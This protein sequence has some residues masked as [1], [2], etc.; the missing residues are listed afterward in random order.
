MP[1][2]T[3]PHNLEAERAV[4]GAC[5]VAADGIAVAHQVVGAGDFWRDA[6]AR[7]WR[8]IG[9]VKDDGLAVDLI[10]VRDRLAAGG[11][12]DAV[13][14]PAYVARLADG[15]PRSTNVAHY[16]RLV[17]K[18]ALARR[19]LLLVE[20]GELEGLAHIAESACALASSEP[21]TG[22]YPAVDGDEWMPVGGWPARSWLVPG[23]L[24]AGRIGMLSGRGG[25]GKSRLALQLA[26]RIAG[27]GSGPFLPPAATGPPP[28]GKALPNVETTGRSVVYASWEDEREEAGRRL[29]AMADDGIAK[30]EG[31]EGRLRYVDLRGAGP[32]WAPAAAGFA[33]VRAR[34]AL[35]TA[36]ARLRATCEGL[37][38][39]LLVV[40]SL[41]GA[42]AGD[43]N[44]R[45]LVRA[46]CAHW[47]AWATETGCAVMLVAHPPKTP[48][49]A[50]AGALDSDYAGSTDWHNAA[51]WR[52]ALEPTPTG[53]YRAGAGKRELP[54]TAPALKV[55]KSSYGPSGACVFVSPSASNLGWKAVSPQA[56][57]AEAARTG[58]FN[59]LPGNGIGQEGDGTG[60]S[61]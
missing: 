58:G 26:A 2:S 46:F 13:G 32:L 61:Y 5:L 15:V 18:A 3:P 40:D 30:P 43:E 8:A 52:W 56:A 45:A 41:A 34:G 38:A 28:E 20:R 42:Y 55:A 7:I 36:G 35:T 21:A 9:A 59:L 16:A 23:W 4:L 39:G 33:H 51:R 54:V 53:R 24:P 60:P 1:E 44:T 22:P 57:A 49:N 25:R 17:R 12:L 47:D 29:A 27:P 6:H 19:A 48:A 37:G 11:D 14:G 10:T 31:L 50:T